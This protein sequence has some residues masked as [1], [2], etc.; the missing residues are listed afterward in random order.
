MIASVATG[1]DGFRFFH[2]SL[3]PLFYLNRRPDYPSPMPGGHDMEWDFTSDHI[4]GNMKL[5]HT[6]KELVGKHSIR[7]LA[8]L[9]EKAK[10]AMIPNSDGI[11][12]GN[13]H[14]MFL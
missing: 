2:A 14:G 10:E 9:P 3:S 6:K 13:S 1:G 5:S 12:R 7:R 8:D 4:I 11:A